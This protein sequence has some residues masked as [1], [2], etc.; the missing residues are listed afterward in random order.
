MSFVVIEL[1]NDNA[2]VR[3]SLEAVGNT[4]MSSFVN[5][6]GG[7]VV[8]AVEGAIEST[9]VRVVVS[10]VVS[11]FMSGVIRAVVSAVMRTVMSAVMRTVMSAV[12]IQVKSILRIC[13][14]FFIGRGNH[15]NHCEHNCECFPRLSRYCKVYKIYSFY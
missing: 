4:M 2:F 7:T 5:A 15:Q 13:D 11:S 14:D 10:A 3:G 6:I 9:V 8:G 1:L 12:V